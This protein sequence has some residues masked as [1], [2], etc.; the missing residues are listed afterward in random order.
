MNFVKNLLL[1]LRREAKR[2]RISVEEVGITSRKVDV[3]YKDIGTTMEDMKTTN[4][5]ISMINLIGT[6]EA[7][8]KIF[9]ERE[10]VKKEGSIYSYDELREVFQANKC[11]ENFFDQ[12]YL[13]ARPLER[14]TR[15]EGIDTLANLGVS[16]TSKAVDQKKQIAD[17]HEK[18][19]ENA[20]SK[21]LDKAFVLNIDDYYN[22][23][24]SWQSD[25]TST[26][27]PAHM[28]T[29]VANLCFMAAIPYNGVLNPKF[30]DSEL[31]IKHLDKQFITTLGIPY[32]E[33][34]QNYRGERSNNELIEKL[35]LHSYN[36]SYTN[37]FD[38]GIVLSCGHGYH[39]CCLQR[40]NFKCLIC[41]GYLK[42][43]IKVNIK[44]LKLSMTKNLGENKFIEEQAEGTGDDESDDTEAV[45]GKIEIEDNLLENAKKTFL[46]AKIRCIYFKK[47][48]INS[49]K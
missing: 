11:L 38:N 4:E 35:T 27:R 7:I 24:I 42:N 16:T 26:S 13:A 15:N 21:Y 45:V 41:L 30:I 43:E 8:A 23:H 46:N 2:V 22:I 34:Y 37:C 28:A 40:C 33:C 10:H 9:Y 44:S 48:L 39:G 6:I 5:D 3:T 17:G 14:G 47:N 29:I 12:L 36:D 31:I 49:F 19:V 20:L 32:H 18:Y 25:S 1:K